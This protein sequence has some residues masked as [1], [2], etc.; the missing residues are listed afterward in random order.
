MGV[1]LNQTKVNSFCIYEQIVQT[2]GVC[3]NTRCVRKHADDE[4]LELCVNPQR[5]LSWVVDIFQEVF[6]S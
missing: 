3:A 6:P 1:A 4:L 2:Q 5:T